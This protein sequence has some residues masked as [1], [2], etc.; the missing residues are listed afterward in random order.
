MIP[1]NLS[2]W[3]KSVAVQL[4]HRLGVR[5]PRSICDMIGLEWGVRSNALRSLWV[6]WRLARENREAA[7]CCAVRP[8]SLPEKVKQL[9]AVVC[10]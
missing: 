1:A 4:Q 9:M 7:W 5:Y 8:V 2:S 3:F 6:W 10:R